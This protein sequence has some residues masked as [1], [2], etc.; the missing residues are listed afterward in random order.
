LSQAKTLLGKQQYQQLEDLKNK[1]ASL[2]PKPDNDI[3]RKRPM[4]SSQIRA[5]DAQRSMTGLA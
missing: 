1:P 4:S 3:S 5:E 2:A